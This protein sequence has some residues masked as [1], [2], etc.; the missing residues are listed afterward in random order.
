[1]KENVWGVRF[2]NQGQIEKALIKNICVEFN[3]RFLE[4]DSE[5]NDQLDSGA[6]EHEV[7]RTYSHNAEPMIKHKPQDLLI[8]KLILDFIMSQ[9]FNFQ[10]RQLIREYTGTHDLEVLRER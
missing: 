10:L 4:D 2:K 7:L 9:Q 8:T 5:A 6:E 3:K 1:M